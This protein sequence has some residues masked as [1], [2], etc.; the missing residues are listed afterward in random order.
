MKKSAGKKKSKKGGPLANIKYKLSKE[1][2]VIIGKDKASRP[3]IM[4]GLWVYIKKNKLQDPNDKR[5]IVFDD[6]FSAVFAKDGKGSSCDMFYLAK[7]ISGHL[8]KI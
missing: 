8:K 7:G 3:E 6:K 2:A 1:L 4:K 5:T